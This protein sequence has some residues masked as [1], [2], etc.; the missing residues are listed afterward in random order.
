[1]TQDR[2]IENLQA[3]LSEE[4]LRSLEL[5]KLLRE[6]RPLDLAPLLLHF[7]PEDKAKIFDHLDSDSAAEVLF[8]T[9]PRSRDEILEHARLDKLAPLFDRMPPDEAAD[10]VTSLP[11][12]RRD[13]L[14]RLSPLL[15]D[16]VRPLL[17]YD[18]ET[19]GGKMTTEYVSVGE[20]ETAGG[21]MRAIQGSIGAETVNYIF[22]VNGEHRLRGVLSIRELIASRP[23]APIQEIMVSD[24]ISAPPE[25]DQEDVAGLV[26]KYNLAA[27]PIV[28]QDGRLLGIVTVDDVIDVIQSEASEDMYHLAGTSPDR[29][30]TQKFH[31][32]VL[33]RFRFLLITLA[34]GLAIVLVQA[35]YGHALESMMAIVFF[36]P[37]IIGMAGNVGIQA[38]TIMVRG[39][40]TGEIQPG[41]FG[42]VLRRE[43]LVGATLGILFGFICGALAAWGSS[44]LGADSD[45]GY[46]VGL[47]MVS[48]LTVA[49]LMGAVVPL[50]CEKL[51]LDPA[52]AAGP[53]VTTLNDLTALT[54]Y[55]AIALTI[56]K[57]EVG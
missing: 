16:H 45:L 21:A 11:P 38:S 37:A 14:L 10:I 26:Q 18:S 32:Q 25:M 23:D 55:L 27:L 15:A 28:R 12:E 44:L 48:G 47:G 40:A 42:S 3:I 20:N 1:M 30:T 19:A 51:G 35:Q 33:D 22:V 24:V 13:P 36:I 8:E 9:D 49:S 31:R 53:F 7:D 57:P 5:I 6:I 54:L 41:R 39:V 46:A 34:G 43:V 29:P 56:L 50:A 4:D 2:P 52:L 17:A